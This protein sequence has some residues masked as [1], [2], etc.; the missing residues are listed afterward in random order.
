MEL[1]E[2]GKDKVVTL[3][4]AGRWEMSPACFAL[5]LDCLPKDAMK[6]ASRAARPTIPRPNVVRRESESG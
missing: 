4:H 2:R 1:R 6:P 5:L 3:V